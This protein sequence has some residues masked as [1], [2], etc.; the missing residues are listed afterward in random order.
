MLHS[1]R[2]SKPRSQSDAMIQVAK[3]TENSTRQHEENK[4]IRLQAFLASERKRDDMFLMKW[5]WPK[6]FCKQHRL[7]VH[8]M[9]TVACLQLH[10]LCHQ[11]ARS[12]VGIMLIRPLV[13]GHRT[14]DPFIV[15][16]DHVKNSC[17]FM[18]PLVFD[19]LILKQVMFQCLRLSYHKN[20]QITKFMQG[21]FLFRI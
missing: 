14:K 5:W 3:S 6:F 7:C 15:I 8:N 19:L 13:V 11:L 1:K 17:W 21:D 9:P 18:Y 2:N 20:W 10:N 12:V 16:C 4:D